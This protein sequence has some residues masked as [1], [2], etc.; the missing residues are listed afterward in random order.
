MGVEQTLEL[1]P[2]A[3]LREG[4]HHQTAFA[5]GLVLDWARAAADEEMERL[6]DEDVP[7]PPEEGFSVVPW[8]EQHTGPL[9]L[10]HN[11]AFADHWGSTPFGEERWRKQIMENPGWRPAL[12]FVAVADAEPIGYAYNEVYEEDWEVAG[13]S[14]GWIGVLSVAQEWR[15]KGVATALLSRSMAAMRAAG[16]DAARIG[17]DSSSPS[18]AQ[19]LYQSVGFRTKTTGTTW[20]REVK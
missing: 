19:H 16:L 12:S 17:V 4:E 9:R 18:G 20:Q 13:Q 7:L 14:E 15:K 1:G 5:F 11:A 8:A 10:V 6:L 2:R 3:R